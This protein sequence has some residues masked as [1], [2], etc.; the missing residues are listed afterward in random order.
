MS[1]DEI[2]NETESLG[3]FLRDAR[4]KQNISLEDARDSTKLSLPILKYIE[5]NDFE[6]MPAEAFCRGF[7]VMYAKYLQ[8]DHTEV[9][10][11]YLDARG[12]SPTPAPKQ[13][14]P[15]VSNSV[16][17]SSYAEPSSVSPR[18]GL[19]VFFLLCLAIIVGTCW[20]VGW[21]PIDFINA[22]LNPSQNNAPQSSPSLAKETP[23]KTATTTEVMEASTKE[24]VIVETVMPVIELKE[25][26]INNNGVAVQTDYAINTDEVTPTTHKTLA[27]TLY[28]LELTFQSTGTLTATLEDGFFMDRDYFTGQ[29]LQWDVQ[30]S[31]LLDMPEAIDVS[32]QLNGTELPLPEAENGRR[33]LSLPEDYL[34]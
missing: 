4:K 16:Q 1:E 11:R 8:L 10:A 14:K 26:A 33:L 34:N 22:Q 19:A 20:Y 23:E 2:V 31:I 29:T 3:D 32:I 28:H 5:S 25:D 30:K 15:P 12:L 17:F 27:T 21:N 13:S 7:Y 24:A 18:A 9:L 6:N